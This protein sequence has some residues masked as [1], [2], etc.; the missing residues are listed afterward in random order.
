MNCSLLL[1]QIFFGLD[2]KQAN[3]VSKRREIVFQTDRQ[4][5]RQSKFWQNKK[6]PL[7]M[8]VSLKRNSES[9]L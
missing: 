1:T 3:K 8:F 7:Q 9:F 4:T 6:D 5:D 2:C